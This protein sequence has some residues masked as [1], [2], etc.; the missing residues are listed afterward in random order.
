MLLSILLSTMT[1]WIYCLLCLCCSVLNICADNVN[2]LFVLFML[3]TL[4]IS[5]PTIWMYCLFCLCCWVYCY[6]PWQCEYIV[7]CAYAVE[8]IVIN[9]DN[10]NIL[11]VLF[12]LFS[13]LL[14]TMTIWI[15]YLLCFCYW[16]YCYQPWQCEY[17]ICFVYAVQYLIINY[18]NVNILF[19]LF[20]L[21]SFLLST[22]TI[23]YV[24]FVLEGVSRP[25]NIAGC[26]ENEIKLNMTLFR[27]SIVITFFQGD[28]I[29]LFSPFGQNRPSCVAC[30]IRQ[31]TLN[32]GQKS[33]L[34]WKFS[35][36]E[37]IINIPEQEEVRG[38]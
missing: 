32:C 15:Y 1:M 9:H 26:D 2:I 6:Q 18:D 25:I 35:Y 34:R 3:F 12:M 33:L 5:A 28:P 23:T 31:Y 24:S 22:M 37:G 13:I 8:Y 10:V 36:L 4:W 16:V 30:Q 19:I 29:Q 21:F 11:F 38:R 17:I 14:S 20:M 7:Y 27:L